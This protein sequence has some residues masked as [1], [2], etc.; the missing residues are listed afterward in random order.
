MKLQIKHFCSKHQTELKAEEKHL[1]KGTNIEVETCPDCLR[2][3]AEKNFRD[4]IL[5]GKKLYGPKS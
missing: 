1:S 4:G 3:V 2:L 5:E